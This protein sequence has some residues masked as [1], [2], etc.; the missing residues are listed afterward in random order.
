MFRNHKVLV[1]LGKI[2]ISLLNW[3]LFDIDVDSNLCRMAKFHFNINHPN[4]STKLF[5]I[6]T[7]LSSPSVHV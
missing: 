2:K 1:N 6:S 4:V 3:S 5:M 7:K